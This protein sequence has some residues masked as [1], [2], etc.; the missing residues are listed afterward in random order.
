MRLFGFPKEYWH[1]RIAALFDEFQ[2]DYA[3]ARGKARW[4]DKTPRY[5]LCIDYLDQLFPTC[6]VVHVIRDGRDVVASHRD[7]W[8]WWAAVKAVKKWPYY[9]ATA[10][11]AGAGLPAGRYHE[12][13]YERLVADPEATL[14]ELLDFLGEPW[15]PA[16]LEHDKRPHDVPERYLAFASSRRVASAERPPIYRS[17]VGSGH[18][19][20]D[21]LLK[22]LVK[23]VA[24][25]TLN[26]L[27]YR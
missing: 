4:A 15:D 10:R 9:L 21:P 18:K 22:L 13:R 11:T 8:G 14:R 19:E 6:Q 12:L 27:G 20:L 7:R 16:V 2:G 1:E 3:R 23:M 26:E 17:R 25:R 24:G 5:A